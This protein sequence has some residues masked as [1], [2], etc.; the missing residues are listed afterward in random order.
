MNMLLAVLEKRCQ[1]KL[2][3]KDVFL[4]IAGGLRVED[5]AINVAIV[6]A[7]LSS[8]T[9]IALDNKTCFAGEMGLSGEVRPV[10]R[11]AQ[12]IAEA[13]KLGFTRMFVSKYNLKGIRPSDYKLKIIPITKVEEMARL[14]FLEQPR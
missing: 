2:G 3:A 14:L 4:N 10:T 6:A 12:R 7:I 13:D 11:I 5:P 8:V 1:F 9:D